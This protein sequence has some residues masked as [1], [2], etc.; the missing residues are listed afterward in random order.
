MSANNK[1]VRVPSRASWFSLRECILLAE[2]LNIQTGTKQP[3]VQSKYKAGTHLHKWSATSLFSIHVG[4]NVGFCVTKLP[5]GHE[6]CHRQGLR[7]NFN[8]LGFFN[9]RL[10]LCSTVRV[11]LIRTL[12][13][14]KFWS[15]YLNVQI[16]RTV[17]KMNELKYYLLLEVDV[18]RLRFSTVM[19]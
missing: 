11:P 16:K 7:I 12:R 15:N 18:D 5:V 3:V 1:Q 19:Q 6:R 13:D 10:N 14:C 2:G 17:P 9:M 4:W 8:H